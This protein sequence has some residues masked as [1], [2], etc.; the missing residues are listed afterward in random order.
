LNL[1]PEFPK[2]TAASLLAP[3]VLFQGVILS[4]SPAIKR[5]ASPLPICNLVLL[6]PILPTVVPAFCKSTIVP[7]EV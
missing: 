7:S 3:V 4:K 6:V 5:P 1:T 2:S